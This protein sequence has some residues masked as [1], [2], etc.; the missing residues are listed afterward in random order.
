VAREA[1]G[2]RHVRVRKNEVHSV[3]ECFSSIRL[4]AAVSIALERS[5]PTTRQ[6][7]RAKIG[8]LFRRN[9]TEP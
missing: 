2:D 9:M 5:T 3:R 7:R 4:A 8:D 1:S 6:P